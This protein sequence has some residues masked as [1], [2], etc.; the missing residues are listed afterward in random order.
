MPGIAEVAAAI[1]EMAPFDTAEEWDNSGILV[2]CGCSA[3]AMMVTLDITPEVVTEAESAGCGLIVSHHPVIFHPM[4]RIEENDVPFMLVRKGISAICAHTNLDAA[5]GGVND[6]LAGMFGI[7]KAQPF[8]GLGRVGPLAEPMAAAA[9]ARTC[10]AALGTAVR[11]V[12]AGRRVNRLA[13][14]GG[15]GGSLL[16]EAMAAGADCLLTGEAKHDEALD[17]LRCGVSLIAAG[18]F[19]TEFPVVPVLARYLSRR[20]PEAKV[21]VTRT[22]R[23]PFITLLPEKNGDKSLIQ[24]DSKI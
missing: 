17:A 24:W 23:D 12:D 1:N 22:A 14:V 19:A 9:L 6:V 20:F 2:D 3:E 21:L 11:V 8:A 4:R 10:A 5:G 13:V 18:H 16:H 15:S 7:E